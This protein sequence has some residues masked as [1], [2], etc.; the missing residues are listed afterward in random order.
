MREDQQHCH[1]LKGGHDVSVANAQKRLRRLATLIGSGSAIAI[2][3]RTFLIAALSDIANGADAN[4]ALGV[5]VRRGER[6]SKKSRDRQV[7]KKYAMAWIAAARLPEE[8]GGLGLTLED[9]C[10]LVSD[11]GL[12][13]HF[14]LTEETLRSYWNKQPELRQ[15]E[16]TQED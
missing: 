11:K 3:D 1:Y 5:K 8:G 16:L 4:K 15:V 6:K 14:H 12:D 2:K 9:A 7:T 13:G 10:A